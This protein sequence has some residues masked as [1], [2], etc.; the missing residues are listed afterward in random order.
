MAENREDFEAIRQIYT[1]LVLHFVDGMKQSEIALAMNLSPSKV[2]RL[3]VQG[4][5]L[6]MVKVAIE[7]PFQPLV[8]LETRL[9]ETGGLS[10]SVVAPTV[11]GS[12]DTTLQQVGRAAA[13]MLLETLR[14]GDIIAITGGKAVS[15]VVENMMPERAFDVTVVPL[16]GGVQGKFYT[17]VNHLASRLAER[18]GGRTLLMHAPLFAESR[19]QRDMLMEMASIRDVF[20]LARKAAIAL[21]GIGSIVTPGSSYYDLNPLTKTSRE[22][23]IE[24]GVRGE[25]LAHL[26]REDGTVADHPLNSRLV[27]LDP[28]ELARC[29][30]RIGVAAGPEKVLPI[31]AALNGRFLDALVIDEETAGDVLEAM[32]PLHNV[33]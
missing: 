18:L 13:N 1:V 25:F 26:I 19:E 27:A 33:A 15:A 6:G 2:N 8:D 17:D 24:S 30:R 12:P 32:E 5:K 23:L 11:P 10:A 14:D 4:R 3:I 7:S 22:L 21:V 16:T 31:R 29:P 20:G 9:I 28:A